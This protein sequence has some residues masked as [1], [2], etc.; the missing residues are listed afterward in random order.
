MVLDV[1]GLNFFM[2]VFAFLFV[3][4]VIY[5]ILLKSRVFGDIPFAYFLTSLV[6]SVIFMSFSSL[7][8]YV[9][10]LVP[11]FVVLFIVVF[12]VLMIAGFSTKSLDKIMT[13]K[14]AWVVVTILVII[15]LIAAIK[16]FNPIFHPDLI[17]SSG[18]GTSMMDQLRGFFSSS[19]VAGSVLLLVIAAVVAFVISKK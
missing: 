11:W 4:V 9:R 15:F 6:V 1:S 3:F 13:S 17:I 10:T 8:L 16:V 14:F 19:K 7:E 18:E 2:P 12:L 5:A